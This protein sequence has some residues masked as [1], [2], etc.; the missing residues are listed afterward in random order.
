MG[1]RGIPG[2]ARESVGKASWPVRVPRQRKDGRRDGLLAIFD[3]SREPKGQNA[4]VSS[5]AHSDPIYSPVFST[6]PADVGR[7]TRPERESECNRPSDGLRRVLSKSLFYLSE[8]I[9]F[10]ISRGPKGQNARVSA[11]V[12]GLKRIQGSI[13]GQ[14]AQAS[15]DLEGQCG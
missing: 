15:A 5:L 7:P 10:A 8:N 3:T 12:E 11:I 1:I 13:W 9:V 6:D 14:G 4:R 2:S